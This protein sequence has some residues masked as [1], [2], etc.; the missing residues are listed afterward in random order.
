[1]KNIL[2]IL[3]LVIGCGCSNEIP[4]DIN[5]AEDM[6]VTRTANL[7]SIYYFG[8]YSET[9]KSRAVNSLA[10]ITAKILFRKVSIS[11]R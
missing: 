7:D 10:T 8:G 1:M 4:F 2:F 6:T 5:R 3:S 11:L 9:V